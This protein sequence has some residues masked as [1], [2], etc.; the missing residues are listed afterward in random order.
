MSLQTLSSFERSYRP[1]LADI[2]G[3]G[4]VKHLQDFGNLWDYA[5]DLFQHG[6]VDDREL[7]FLDLLPGPSGEY[8]QGLGFAD[9]LELPDAAEALAAWR[10]GGSRAAARTWPVRRCTPARDRAAPSSCGACREHHHRRPAARGRPGVD[11]RPRA[12]R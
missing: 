2:L 4:N 8:I 9:G 3:D 7:Y 10:P 6:F 12:D 1:R 5:R 11:Q